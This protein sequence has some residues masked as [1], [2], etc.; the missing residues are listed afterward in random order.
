[1]LTCFGAEHRFCDRIPRRD[2]LRAGALGLSGL[3]LPEIL[4]LQAQAK[5]T[6]TTATKPR[7]VIMVC[8][9]G[10]PSHLDMYD[11]KPDAPSEYRGEFKPIRSNV[12]GFELCEHL[13]LQATIADKLA[14]VRTV[15][16]VE[17]M[18]HEL[19]EVYT[20]YPKSAKRPAFGSII[21]RLSENRPDVPSYV[22]LEYSEGLTSYE[23]PRY[24]GAGHSP[25]HVAGGEGVR[26]LGMQPGMLRPRLDNRRELLQTFDAI[27]RNVDTHREIQDVDPFTAKALD[28]VTS[29]KARD[30]FDLSQESPLVLKRYGQRDDKF[31]Y[32]G[33]EPD[34]I[35]DSQK[36]LLARRLVEAGVP[37][38]TLR[39][40]LWDHHGNVIQQVGGVSIWHS[41]RS[42]LPLLDRSIHALVTDLHERSELPFGEQGQCQPGDSAS[43]GKELRTAPYRESASESQQGGRDNQRIQVLSSDPEK[44]KIAEA[45]TDGS[46]KDSLHESRSGI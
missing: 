7:S 28:L 3:S 22:S 11:L 38:V 20:G 32:V 6:A 33:K 34:S 4:R 45:S 31:T 2:F 21:S 24:A 46:G 35:W 15:Q 26:N 23:H 1:M 17:P 18:Q 43:D 10:G 13:P 8:L 37:V 14:L 36:F 27:R 39:M 9:A 5:T 40:G 16:F 42:A 41:L 30:A 12:P 25:L 29:S 19:E 44:R